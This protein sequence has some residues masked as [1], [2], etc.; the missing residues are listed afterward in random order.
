MAHFLTETATFTAQ[1]R[2]PDGTDPGTARAADVAFMA[3]ALANRTRALK[4]VT[5]QAAVKNASNTF[6]GTNSFAAVN[7]TSLVVS[8]TTTLNGTVNAADGTINVTGNVALTAQLSTANILLTDANSEIVLGAGVIRYVN[9]PLCD[10]LALNSNADYDEVFDMWRVTAATG[11]PTIRFQVRGVPRG[12]A[13]IGAE[14]VWIGDSGTPNSVTIRYNQQAAWAA[15]AGALVAPTLP[16]TLSTLTQSD[17]FS[18]TQC[19]KTVVFIPDLLTIDNSRQA[20]WLDVELGNSI[21]N[22]LHA[23][24]FLYLDPGPR[25]G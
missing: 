24:R 17:G 4:V 11:A 6:T 2:V 23:V 16:T 7:A 10:G 20:F 25:N 19:T 18:T 5:D 1:V 14:A 21:D 15:A 8:G 9:I 22:R 13:A 12:A 3:Q